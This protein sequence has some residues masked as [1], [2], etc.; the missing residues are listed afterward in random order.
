MWQDNSRPWLLA[1]EDP[2]E[3]GRDIGGGT[4]NMPTIKDACAEA[5]AL[6]RQHTTTMEG[7]QGGQQ[8]A[9]QEQIQQQQQVQQQQVQQQTPC[10][11]G[12]IIDVLLAVGRGERA[13]ALRE[14]LNRRAGAVLC[15]G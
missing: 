7:E 2:Q 10:M 6:L 11:L 3:S 4:F 14:T 1:V 13:R 12:R 15:I 8:Q 9:K 5:A